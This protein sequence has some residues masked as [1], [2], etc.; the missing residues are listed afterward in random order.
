MNKQYLIGID[1]GTGSARAGIFDPDGTMVSSA[2]HP[3]QIWK[4]KTDFVEQSSNDIWEAVCITVKKAL[5]DSGINKSYIAGI[6]F[7]AT[8]SLVVLG[9][10]NRPLPVTNGES[11]D[12]NI[13]VW[14]DHR[15][16]K[17][18]QEIN[19]TAHRVL[20]YVGGSI[21]PEMQTPKLLWLKRNN[22]RT[23]NAAAKFFDLP[24]F[25]VY[26]A[27]GEDVRSLCSTVC[28]WTYLGHEVQANKEGWSSEFFQK[29]GLE[30]EVENGFARIGN[31]I[32]AIG[33]AVGKGLTKSSAEELGLSENTPVG[34][35]IIDAHAGGLGLLGMNSEEGSNVDLDTKLALIGGT[36][37][38]HMVVSEEPKFIDGVWG[39]YYSAMIPSFWLNE[40]GQ[41][42]T[43]A[44]IDHIIFS[45]SLYDSL[46]EKAE[47]DKTT[48]YDLL[49]DKLKSLC[50]DRNL[51]D[52]GLLTQDLNV[53]PYFH[54]NRSPR[55]NASLTGSIA[56][57][58][59]SNTEEDLAILY[60]ATIQAI[61]Y[62]T[63]HIIDSMNE[64]G[65]RINQ[66]MATGGGTKN[67]IFLQQH[68]DIT[69]C[70]MILGK[71]SESVLLGSAVLG[72]VAGGVYPDVVLAMKKLSHPGQKIMP[73]FELNT[74]NYHKAKYKIFQ[75]MHEDSESYRVIMSHE[76]ELINK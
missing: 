4:T 7:D 60:L 38:C 21:S 30:D 53:L 63:K 15:A 64:K 1:V 19:K 48:V 72:A 67:E 2:V 69:G 42:A 62:G 59:L 75:K 68:A 9:D 26:K 56:G 32:R 44:L 23:W 50:K 61:A 55:A 76:M 43:G 65:Y 39:P 40:G 36:S 27:T 3:I 35:S 17:E 13:I 73:S 29:I 74:L 5:K 45:S 37:S 12:R 8:C 49:N 46:K 54:G 20:D 51:T 52:L 31:K 10:H 71:E 22:P 14:M 28:K 34:V 24:D 66:I 6:G 16:K 33:E 18:T 47:V 58:H 11:E 57:L 25:L 70:E 41:S